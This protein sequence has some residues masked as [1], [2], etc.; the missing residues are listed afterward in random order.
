MPRRTLII[1]IGCVLLDAV[2]TS[3]KMIAMQSGLNTTVTS[4]SERVTNSKRGILGRLRMFR[5]GQDLNDGKAVP[6]ETSL[7]RLLD[8]MFHY[9]D[10]YLDADAP[11]PRRRGPRHAIE[12]VYMAFN[13]VR[14]GYFKG[15]HCLVQGACEVGSALINAVTQGDASPLWAIA[16]GNGSDQIIKGLKFFVA[17][18]VVASRQLAVGLYKTPEAIRATNFGMSYQTQSQKTS[19][20]YYW[21]DKEDREI[22]LEEETQERLQ[23]SD[24]SPGGGRSYVR[25]RRAS[26]RDATLYKKLGVSVYADAREIKTAYRRQALHVHPDK[27]PVSTEEFIG[28]TDAYRVLVNDEMRDRYDRDGLCFNKQELDTWP[29]EQLDIVDE[30]FGTETVSLYVGGV[31]I[32]PEANELLGFASTKE[33]K[34]IQ[35]LKQKRRVVDIA[36]YIRERVDPVI[37]GQTSGD[38]FRQS[39][40]KEAHFL[41]REGADPKLLILIGQTLVQEANSRLNNAAVSIVHRT[42]RDAKRKTKTQLLRSRI[43]LPAYFRAALEGLVMGDVARSRDEDTENCSPRRR[44]G[45]ADER[46]KALELL[47]SFVEEDI[48]TTLRNAIEKFFHDSRGQDSAV[49]FA[50]LVKYQRANAVK[51]LGEE[52]IAVVSADDA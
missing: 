34:E 12:G 32:S 24:E 27:S 9:L 15:T 28:L 35:N 3:A 45:T 38:A 30:I 10:V 21:L 4:A 42:L 43:N 5:N 36:M 50:N 49:A 18:A 16:Y 37:K 41:L 47:W 31:S 2:R 20:E 51:I 22:R 14:K 23:R 46:D 1:M 26:V 25:K 7:T 33:P 44:R 8:A 52:M 6:D 39:C 17:G 13:S 29:Q 11:D 19:W 48:G 40:A